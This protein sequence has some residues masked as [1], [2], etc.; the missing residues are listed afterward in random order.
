MH[1]ISQIKRAVNPKDP[2]QKVNAKLKNMHT[3]RLFSDYHSR[4]KFEI[5]CIKEVFSFDMN[6]PHKG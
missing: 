1:Q 5:T 2:S 3:P 4:V 6:T